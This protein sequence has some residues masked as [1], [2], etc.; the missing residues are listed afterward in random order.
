MGLGL[1][2]RAQGA[3]KGAGGLGDWG[4]MGCGG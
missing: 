2:F 3:F 1:E 4:V